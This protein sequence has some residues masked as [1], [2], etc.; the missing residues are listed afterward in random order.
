LQ[1]AG[2]CGRSLDYTFLVTGGEKKQVEITNERAYGTVI[3]DAV[4]FIPL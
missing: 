1:A 4:L 2:I 3:A